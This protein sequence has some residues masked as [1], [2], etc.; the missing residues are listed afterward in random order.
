[1]HSDAPDPQKDQVQRSQGAVQFAVLVLGLDLSDGFSS[2][3]VE[4]AAPGDWRVSHVHPPDTRRPPN[5]GPI[6]GP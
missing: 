1:M 5:D 4:G 6:R 3:D 2:E